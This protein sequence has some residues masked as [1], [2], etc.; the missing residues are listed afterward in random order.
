[1]NSEFFLCDEVY[2]LIRTLLYFTS[3]VSNG[4]VV[5]N[6]TFKCEMIHSYQLYSTSKKTS[7]TF[8]LQ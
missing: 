1:M 7:D 4:K 2:G 5:W 3:A 8:S 6:S